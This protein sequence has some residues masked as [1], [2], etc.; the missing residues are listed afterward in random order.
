[1]DFWFLVGKW[2]DTDWFLGFGCLVFG[3]WIWFFKVWMF[4]FFLG[5]WIDTDY[6]FGFGFFGFQRIFRF[7]SRLSFD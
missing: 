6:F 4:G 5:K 2:M 1:L 3:I 7:V